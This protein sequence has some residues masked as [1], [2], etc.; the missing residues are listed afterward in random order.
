MSLLKIPQADSLTSGVIGFEA[1]GT[2]A[3]LQTS[4]GRDKAALER[5][6]LATGKTTV[7]GS[8][9]QADVDQIWLEPEDRSSRR[10]S[11]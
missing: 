7:L 8:S 1:N 9:D 2:T 5:V 10:R 4:V 3:L 6:D 11:R